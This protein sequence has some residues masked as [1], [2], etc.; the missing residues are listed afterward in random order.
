MIEVVLLGT[1]TPM[2]DP[3]RCGSG[4]AVVNG[5]RWVLVDCGRGVTQRVVESGLDLAAID[6]VV[7]SHHHSDHVSD[8]ATLAITRW[9]DGATTPLVVVVP[10]G[11]CGRFARRC[12]D[13]F[14]DQAFHSQAGPGSPP[15]PTVAVQEFA[16]TDHPTVVFDSPPWTVRSALVDHHPIEAAVGYR[17][18]VGGRVVAV[19]GDTAVCA[20]IERLAAGADLLIHEALR[21]DR[22]SPAA[23]TWNASARSVGELAHALDLSSVVLTHLLPAP[24][25]PEEERAF[26]DE[27]RAGGFT[28]ELL[29][30]RD[31]QRLTVA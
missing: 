18:E 19:S 13:G 3:T 24:E 5:H 25:G 1:G 9:V 2:P 30:A 16:P 26:I 8:L 17:I 7:L 14:E 4:V 12:L 10:S 6:A 11:P 21:S 15:R 22:V 23:L 29:V 20:G 28:G 31:R 27:T